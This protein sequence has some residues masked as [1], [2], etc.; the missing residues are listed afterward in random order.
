MLAVQARRVGHADT[1]RAARQRNLDYLLRAL[2]EMLPVQLVGPV[3]Q[4]GVALLVERDM[5]L[6]RVARQHDVGGALAQHCH[7]P[8]EG[9]WVAPWGAEAEQPRMRRHHLDAEAIH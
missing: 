8:L 9:L 5:P 4:D 6:T 2:D 7:V 1:R 3:V